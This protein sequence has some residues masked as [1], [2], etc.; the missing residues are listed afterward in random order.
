MHS[1]RLL[2]LILVAVAVAAAAAAAAASFGGAAADDPLV[3]MNYTCSAPEN[4]TSGSRYAKNLAELLSTLSRPAAAVDNWWFRQHT[5]NSSSRDDQVSGLAMCFADSEP[6]RCRSCL[7]VVTSGDDNALLPACERSRDV[8][9][10]SAPKAASSAT[11]AAAPFFFGSAAADGVNSG[12]ARL[13]LRVGGYPKNSDD[14][15][16]TRESS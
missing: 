2:L 13:V 7:A 6:D 14:N 10:S 12:G 16:N 15:P 3:Y 5:V 4:Y 11:P 1:A 8:S 9:A